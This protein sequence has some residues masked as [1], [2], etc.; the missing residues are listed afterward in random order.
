MNDLHAAAQQALD[1]IEGSGGSLPFQAYREVRVA[2][3]HAIQPCNWWEEDGAWTTGCAKRFV[4]E[5]GTP[6]ENSMTYC[7]YC[8][9]VIKEVEA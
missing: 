3:R 6:E 2:L 7:C 9:S 1:A 5:A 4:L 8:G